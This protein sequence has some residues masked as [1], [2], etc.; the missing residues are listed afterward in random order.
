MEFTALIDKTRQLLQIDA[1]KLQENNTVCLSFDDV[2]VNFKAHDKYV[3]L[4]SRLAEV[5][6]QKTHLVYDFLLKVSNFGRFN[7]YIGLDNKQ[8]LLTFV[9]KELL[10]SLD[11][12]YFVQCLEKHV[13]NIEFLRLSL[14]DLQ[15]MPEKESVEFSDTVNML[16][17]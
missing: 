15:N 2:I 5:P 1:L 7:A 13:Q 14:E 17:A 16:R 10:E 3:L 4:V 11:E 8:G 12:H 9:S 6:K